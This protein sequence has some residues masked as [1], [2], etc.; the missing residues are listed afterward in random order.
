MT[1]NLVRLQVTRH[2]DVIEVREKINCDLKEK[3]EIDRL[4][5]EIFV[6]LEV[7]DFGKPVIVGGVKTGG[8]E[9]T[10]N[11]VTK[12]VEVN[13]D[14]GVTTGNTRDLTNNEQGIKMEEDK[15]SKVDKEIILEGIMVVGVLGGTRIIN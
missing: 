2:F 5:T 4:I 15:V 12:E 10:M 13:K 11:W 9:V 3:R 7:K 1:H 8:K 6:G 14:Q